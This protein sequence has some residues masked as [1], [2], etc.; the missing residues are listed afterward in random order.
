MLI[1]DHLK[2]LMLNS[3]HLKH[4]IDF[5][6]EGMAGWKK[7]MIDSAGSGLT[8]IIISGKLIMKPFPN[9]YRPLPD[10]RL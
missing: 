1:L 3:D 8:F 2:H 6:A 10:G 4:R 7:N 5:L 9:A